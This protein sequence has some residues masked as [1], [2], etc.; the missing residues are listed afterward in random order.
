MKITVLGAA[1]NIGHRIVNEALFRGH[2]VT[3]VVRSINRIHTL[4]AKVTS[5]I[6]NA[7]NVYDIVRL[8]AGQDLVINA[9]RSA[10]SDVEEVVMVTKAIMQGLASTG[11]R[12]LIVGGAASLS[13][14][15][16]NGKKVIDAPQFLAPSLRHVGEASV[17]QYQTCLQ[18]KRVNW[19]YLSPAANLKPG[20][21]TGNYRLGRDELVVD[22]QGAST[23][24]I[25]DLAVV[26]MD[27]AENPRHQQT[28]FTAAY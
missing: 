1:G 28:R 12:L 23:I 16:T 15:G 2:E 4:P 26:V 5:Q 8:S 24:S 14:P 20:K 7:T 11:V 19:S 6:A 10:S 9:T 22:S 27:E 3:A 18:E 25:E 13:V 21:R 17:A